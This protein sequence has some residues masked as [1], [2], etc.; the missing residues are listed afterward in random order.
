MAALLVLSLVSQHGEH[1][2]NGAKKIYDAFRTAVEPPEYAPTLSPA[3]EPAT[4]RKAPS[5]RSPVA[6]QMP[7]FD[8]RAFFAEQAKNLP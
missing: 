6:K 5:T 8:S 3:C 7:P 2:I 1:A 4:G